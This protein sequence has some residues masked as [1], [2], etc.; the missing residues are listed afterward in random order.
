MTQDVYCI[1]ILILREKLA[2]HMH[3]QKVDVHDA[4]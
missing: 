1:R 4:V 3:A 2:S